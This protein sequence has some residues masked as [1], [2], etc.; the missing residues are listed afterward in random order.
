MATIN[1]IEK[2]AL[3]LPEPDRALLATSLLTS[4]SPVLD[5]PDE[6]VSEALRRDRELDVQPETAMSIKDLDQKIANRPRCD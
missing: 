6:G 1:E 2:I 3:S 4:L 5:D